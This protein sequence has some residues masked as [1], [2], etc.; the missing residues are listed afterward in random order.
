MHPLNLGRAQYGG[1]HV[2]HSYSVG[3][4]LGIAN[5]IS[6]GRTPSWTT[7][8]TVFVLVLVIVIAAPVGGRLLR[9]GIGL[10]IL[11]AHDSPVV[12]LVQRGQLRHIVPS[13]SQPKVQQ[14]GT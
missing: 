8:G 12:P 11:V 9:P 5:L 6:V 3:L 2:A 13:Y 14:L 7:I 4:C 10:H 1:V